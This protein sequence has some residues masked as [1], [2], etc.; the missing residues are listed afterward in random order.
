[1]GF[2][3]EHSYH[4]IFPE[5]EAILQQASEDSHA[6]RTLG[7]RERRVASGAALKY[8][9]TKIAFEELHKANLS[10]K[11]ARLNRREA[12]L[13]N[14]CDSEI[15]G[16]GAEAIARGFDETDVIMDFAFFSPATD[17]IDVGS[18]VHNSEL[19]NSF[20]S[21]TDI[22]ESG[23]VSEEVL[24]RVYDA[25]AHSCAKMYTERYLTPSV[26]GN[27]ACFTWHILNNRHALLRRI[28]LGYLKARKTS[29]GQYEADFCKA[30][31]EEYR[32]TGV[33]R[34]LVGTCNGE[35]TCDKMES[36]L[37]QHP[38]KEIL[39]DLWWLLL[40]GL[41]C[42]DRE[43]EYTERLAV[44]LAKCYSLELVDEI[45][46]ILA[47]VNQHTWQVNYLF[48]AAMFGSLLNDSS[49]KGRLDRHE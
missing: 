21:T 23:V 39:T 11:T 4:K 13:L 40:T 12:L 42:S 43:K 7:G 48:E 31:D 26:K 29:I 44:C 17:V 18:D 36:K 15:W 35:E 45:S 49:L 30:F 32:T 33:S 46:W 9:K 14:F 3:F 22:T 24:R 34:P 16:L 2:Y 8:T 27:A 20:L 25:Y 1:M 28:V 6:L 38:Q 19:F 10:Y 41:V 47:H 5:F 37:R